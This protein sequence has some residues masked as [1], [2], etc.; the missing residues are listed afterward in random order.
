MQTFNSLQDVLNSLLPKLSSQHIV[1][2]RGDLASGKTT[3]VQKFAQMIGITSPITSPTFGIQNLYTSAKYTLYHYDLYRKNLEECLE[4][5]L[6][7]MLDEK[8]WH[9]VEWG[10][11]ALEKLLKQS[12]FA[13][14]TIAI[15][16]D[17]SK[18]TYRMSQ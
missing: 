12:G 11:E 4:L 17:G 5:G 7:D 15:T 18:R 16:K 6:L 10:E 3:L 13:M 9:F 8:G 2:L 1:L 14:I